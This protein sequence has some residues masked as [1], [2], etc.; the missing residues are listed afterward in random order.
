MFFKSYAQETTKQTKFD[1]GLSYKMGIGKMNTTDL[2]NLNGN[3]QSKEILFGYSLKEH[4]KISSGISL[5]EFN[6]NIFTKDKL[7]NLHS[8]FLQIPLKLHTNYPMSFSENIKFVA[9][10]GAISSYH[11]KTKMEDT[12]DSIQ[13]KNNRWHFGITAEIGVSFAITKA[14]QMGLL[15]ES[16][17][18]P[19]FMKDNKLNVESNLMK[20][21]FTYK[22]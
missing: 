17:L 15:I 3:V 6:T 12:T 16:H 9:G 13:D 4:L 20:L 21:A 1:L 22:I 18:N 10:V 8:N 2:K 11:L 14:M 5:L 19:S 7:F